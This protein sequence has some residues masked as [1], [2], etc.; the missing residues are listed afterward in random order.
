[1]WVDCFAEWPSDAAAWA[2][3]AER[4]KVCLVSPELQGHGTDAIA[5]FRAGLGDRRW[6]AACTKRP[7]LWG[8]LS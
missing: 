8:A 4:F 1:V 2:K 7:D 5:R 3:I 6:D